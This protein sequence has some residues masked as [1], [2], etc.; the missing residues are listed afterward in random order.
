M[1]RKEST[2]LWCLCIVV[3]A[4]FGTNALDILLSA[5]CGFMV[6]TWWPRPEVRRRIMKE[7]REAMAEEPD[8]IKM[9]KDVYEI[10]ASLV[11]GEK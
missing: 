10:E 11:E 6:G 9:H 5:L 7:C 1:S 2:L 8:N 4:A 3:G